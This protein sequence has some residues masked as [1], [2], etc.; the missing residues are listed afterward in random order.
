MAIS[1][2][3]EA[4]SSLKM[5]ISQLSQAET[6]LSHCGGGFESARERNPNVRGSTE[7]LVTFWSWGEILAGYAKS[8]QR[9]SLNSET[10]YSVGERKN[11]A[12]GGFD[13]IQQ[14]DP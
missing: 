4:R 3:L 2:S 9:L 6:T 13:P 14:I 10:G 12:Q 8:R 11:N 5:H 7:F 1:S